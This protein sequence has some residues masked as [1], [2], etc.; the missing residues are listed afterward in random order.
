M[1]VR[2]LKYLVIFAQRCQ[3]LWKVL[4][5]KY[6]LGKF[7]KFKIPH[8]RLSAY[9]LTTSLLFLYNLASALVSKIPHGA[10]TARG[11]Y[12]HKYLISLSY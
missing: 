12:F 9:L 11:K 3:K 2:S 7:S 8:R 5:G 4:R 1:R 6:I 10:L